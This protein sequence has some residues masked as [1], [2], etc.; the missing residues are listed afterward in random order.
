MYFCNK[1]VFTMPALSNHACPRTADSP[2]V[3]S[4]WNVLNK[5]PIHFQLIR[6]W[7][8]LLQTTEGYNLKIIA[9]PPDFDPAC[10][11]SLQLCEI[12]TLINPSGARMSNQSCRPE[13]RA[14]LW[15]LREAQRW[16]AVWLLSSS[17][18]YPQ[19]PRLEL[20]VIDSVSFHSAVFVSLR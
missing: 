6:E 17:C 3:A 5:H 11:I 18:E 2:A 12:I 7:E 19:S 9:V 13:P 16:R 20:A 15:H 4:V 8:Q 14:A 10:A 1:W